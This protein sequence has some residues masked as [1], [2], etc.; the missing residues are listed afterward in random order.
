MN[1]ELVKEIGKLGIATILA[2]GVMFI[3]YTV[4]KDDEQEQLFLRDHMTRQTEA[5]ERLVQIYAGD[6]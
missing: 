4:V 1:V 6:G 5:L 2:I 3:L